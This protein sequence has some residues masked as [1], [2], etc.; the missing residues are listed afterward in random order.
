MTLI[1]QISDLHIAAGHKPYGSVDTTYYLQTLITHLRSFNPPL[2]ALVIT[3]DLAQSGEREAYRVIS[4]I[5]EPLKCPVYLVP[6]NH[7]HRLNIIS[8]LA[9][10][11]PPGALVRHDL[12]PYL[13]GATELDNVRLVIFDGVIE[14]AHNGGLSHE[15]GGFLNEVLSH[16]LEVP[17][18]VFTH[19]PPYFSGLDLM[20]EPY[21]EARK[22]AH[23]LSENP[24]VSLCCG[25]IHR[26]LTTQWAGC[27]SV[28]CPSLALNMELDLT[29]GGG[30]RFTVSA[31]SYV[32]Y[33]LVDGRLNTH[34]CQ[35]P[36]T[37]P[38]SGPYDF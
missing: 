21:L 26:S 27:Q 20:D 37:Y 6:G 38:Y 11:C 22:L 14:G 25:H 34:F 17:T 30:N 18:L 24:L 12:Q 35:A 29:A 8:E 23:I 31:P 4:K 10:L 5:L 33:H 2:D 3:G 19:H 1:A 15:V 7:D 13:C 28:I 32:L 36:G 16:H 9:P